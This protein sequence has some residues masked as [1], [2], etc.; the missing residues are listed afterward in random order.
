MKLAAIDAVVLA[1]AAV[2]VIVA[3]L[4]AR[5][6][7]RSVARR[8]AA[9]AA[10][11]DYQGGELAGKPG[12]ER[13]LSRLERMVEAAVTEQ[14]NARLAHDR[15]VGALNAVRQGIVV[16]DE[17][18]EVVYRNEVATAFMD[19]GQAEALTSQAVVDLLHAASEGTTQTQTIEVYGPPQHVITIVATA[20]DDA[21][22]GL[23]AVAVIDDVTDQRHLEAVRR[24][25][26][27]NVSHELKTPVAALALVAETLADEE[28]PDIVSGLARRLQSE[29]RRVARIFDDLLD[30]SRAESEET[31]ARAPVPIHVAVAQA[32]EHVRTTA[33]ER[34]V[35]ITFSQSSPRL[36]IMGDR[37]QLV[38]AL[39]NLLENAVKY[40]DAGTTVDVRSR[41]DGEWVE[42]DVKDAG[43]G[44]PGRDLS[45]IFERFYRVDR[46]RGGDSGGT[47]LG[48]SIVRHVAAN[49]GGEVRVESREGE[50]STFTL[51]L[52]A[53]AGTA[54]IGDVRAG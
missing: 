39:F 6:S 26:V 33:E 35:T 54:A 31:P 29:S 18:G 3:L 44:I 23:G 9:L 10:R 4:W 42:L 32:A 1:T 50:G 25:F 16:C 11:L 34:G 30:L 40:S 20:L 46:G 37:R 22:R 47:G 53:A 17:S 49:H 38:S 51:R 28:D 8:L 13:D 2:L 45:R 41:S 52:P 12:V 14:G 19:T 24:D 15:L 48:L 43:I 36:S 27:A 21:W 5:L 7:R